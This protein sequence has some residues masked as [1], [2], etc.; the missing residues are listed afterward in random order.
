MDAKDLI[1]IDGRKVRESS[2]LMSVYI[3]TFIKYFGYKPNCAGCT[4][5]NDFNKL[6]K[7]VE[8]KE[9]PKKNIIIMENTE[10]TFKLKKVSGKI[11]T[12]K[13]GKRP[14]RRYDY[15][16]TEEFVNAF[17]S[18]GSKEDIQER[19]TLFS[20]LPDKFK[21]KEKKEADTKEKEEESEKIPSSVETVNEEEK[22]V[23][24][25]KPGRRKKSNK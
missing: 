14:F 13:I 4:F 16:L 11:L 8:S 19:K 3:D 18:N 25:K 5:K 22:P 9:K 15:K 17:L 12:Y 20:V 21:P 6:K 24:K 23:E 7:A 2:N 1:L 10:K